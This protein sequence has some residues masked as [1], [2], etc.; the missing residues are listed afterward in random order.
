MSFN[1]NEYYTKISEGDI[2]LAYKGSITSEL[3]NEVLETVESKLE[4]KNED[5][6][7]LTIDAIVK[8]CFSRQVREFHKIDR[9][10]EIPEGYLIVEGSN[11]IDGEIVRCVVFVDSITLM[12]SKPIQE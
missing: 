3:I 1:I 6:K 5:G 4:A 10:D 8:L 2:L 7:T 12:V 11:G 9:V